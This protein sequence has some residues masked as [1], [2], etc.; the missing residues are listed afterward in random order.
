MPHQS[1]RRI[2]TNRQLN[3]TLCPVDTHNKKEMPHT[4]HNYKID[5]TWNQH[6]SIIL[7]V[8]LDRIFR[9]YYVAYKGLPKSWRSK[10]VMEVTDRAGGALFTPLNLSCLNRKLLEAYS[11]NEGRNV[12]EDKKSEYENRGL[13][14]Q[15]PFEQYFEAY[16]KDNE[17]Y[18][19][20]VATMDERIANLYSDLPIGFDLSNLFK[21]YPFLE[22]YKYSLRDHVKRISETKFKMSYQI[23]YIEAEPEYDKNG[24]Q[25]SRGKLS[26]LYYEMTDFQ[27]IFTA[28]F[29]D[30]IIDINFKSPLGKM[31]L[32]NIL[33]LDTD[34]IPEAAMT[35][36]K[37]A[38]FLY[39]RFVLN[40]VSAKK[41]PKE[42][43]KTTVIELWFEDIK[44]FLDMNPSRNSAIYATIGTAFKEMVQKGL[45]TGYTWKKYA[46]QRK[47]Q[48]SFESHKK[49]PRN[50]QDNDD[51]VLKLPV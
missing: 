24:K 18:H 26:N 51:K 45:I 6:Q 2:I 8:I 31:I 46:D 5:G 41:K 29:K 7:D 48:L 9:G 39:K 25:I 12:E 47:Y 50:K 30:D 27:Q 22:R 13:A 49:E 42:K 28:E 15:M 3:F 4:L 23:K 32:R 36:T 11:I 44:K 21:R 38:Y 1:N 33:I 19:E 20:F 35:L 34:W 17:E 43:K 40:R 16:L 10:K 37:N 14:S